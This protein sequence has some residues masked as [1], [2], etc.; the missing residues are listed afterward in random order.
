MNNLK[1]VQFEIILAILTS[2]GGGLL[3]FVFEKI[4]IWGV[5]ALITFYILAIVLL[6]LQ[7]LSMEET[8]NE[9]QKKDMDL[10]EEKGKKETEERNEAQ[11][12]SIRTVEYMTSI[13]RLISEMYQGNIGK[14]KNNADSKEFGYLLKENIIN[15]ILKTLRLLFEGDTRGSVQTSYPH[16]YFKVAL[17]EVKKRNSDIYLERAFFDYPEGIEPTD[18]TRIIDTKEWGR[19]GHVLSY[20]NQEIIVI[21]DIQTESKKPENETRWRNIR[22]NQSKDYNS[23]VCVPIVRGR[24]GKQ[25]REVLAILVIDTNRKRYFKEGDPHYQ[26]FLGSILSLYRTV[27]TIAYDFNDLFSTSGTNQR[28]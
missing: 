1:L 27:L 19:A 23:M 9:L 16:N 2:L 20:K 7:K 17:F 21:E 3:F 26:A 6:I 12:L 24:R 4:P 11:N 15:L 25:N 14:I 10:Q 13:L 8:K 5:I 22:H 18:K 28:Q